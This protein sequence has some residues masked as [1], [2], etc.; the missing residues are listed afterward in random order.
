MQ[1][2]CMYIASSLA[3][4]FVE[5]DLSKALDSLT[6]KR[7]SCSPKLDAIADGYLVGNKSGNH[8]QIICFCGI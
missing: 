3:P 6:T 8:L 2:D 7:N 5:V 4:V 1:V